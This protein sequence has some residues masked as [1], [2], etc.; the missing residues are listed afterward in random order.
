MGDP[1]R[2]VIVCPMCSLFAYFNLFRVLIRW[3]FA[4]MNKKAFYLENI[5]RASKWKFLVQIPF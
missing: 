2:Q 3:V 1:N 4:E 5:I